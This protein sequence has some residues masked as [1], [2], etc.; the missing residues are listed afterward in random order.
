M[1]LFT[2]DAFDGN[3][4]VYRVHRSLVLAKCYEGEAVSKDIVSSRHGFYQDFREV[5]NRSFLSGVWSHGSMDLS[6]DLKSL[7]KHK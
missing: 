5:D 6:V 1:M 2:L 4:F 7:N 3:R